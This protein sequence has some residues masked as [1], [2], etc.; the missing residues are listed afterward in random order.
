MSSILTNNGAMVALQTMRN[1][2]RGM[3]TTQ[4]QIST[5][6]KV[7][8]AKDNAAT[9]AISKVMESDVAGFG[10][11]KESLALG[12]S[13]V[14]VARNAAETTTKLLTEIKEKIV[15]SQEQNVDRAKIQ[16]DIVQLRNQIESVVNSAQ[17][18]GLNMVDGKSASPVDVLSSLDRTGGAVVAS[19]ISVT[20]ANMTQRAGSPLDLD[21][22]NAGFE[23]ATAVTT[24][25]D[26][27]TTAITAAIGFQD[28]GDAISRTAAA[29]DVTDLDGALE[30]DLVALTV[31]GLT[32]EYRIQAGDDDE[33]ISN[34]LAT[35]LN[36]L[37]RGN[38][39][40]TGVTFEV[41]GGFVAINNAS[42]AGFAVEAE[43]AIDRDRGD[44]ARLGTLDV[45]GVGEEADAN[46]A[47]AL[48]DIE[49]MIQ[50]AIDTS[51]SFGSV[52]KRIEIQ[53]DFVNGLMDSLR[54]GI[55]ALVDADMEETSARLQALQVQ[56][57]L[58]IQALTIAN[59]Q[60]QNILALFR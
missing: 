8:S 35:Q 53:S 25:N 36:N 11:I 34:A 4:S 43:Y 60:P 50:S 17:F 15:L 28:G 3:E 9:W 14:N 32:A 42:G 57:Q 22:A 54:S 40:F 39:D 56:Q 52:Q 46:R 29:A 1:I 7:G 10:A 38:A 37:A 59:Q 18:N 47:R 48:D 44:L 2:N 21:A 24:V 20:T 45:T 33:A 23:P 26:G 30:G 6:L 55:G 58:G 41:D 51:A 49:R 19:S 5:G 12:S 31:N 27:D 16:E 13:T